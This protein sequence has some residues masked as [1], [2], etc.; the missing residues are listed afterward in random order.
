MEPELIKE[1]SFGG[2]HSRSMRL[3]HWSTV[4]IIL[5]SLTTVLLAKTLFNT[6][7][8][9]PLVK[10]SLQKNNVVITDIQARSVTHEFND[11]IWKWHIYFGYVLAGL[12]LFRIIFEFFQPKDQKIIPLFKNSLRALRLPNNDSREIKHYFIVKCTYILFYFSLFVQTCTGLFM[13]YSDDI[14]SL[15]NIRNTVSDIHSVFMWVIITFIVVHIG[16]VIL[17]EL[18]KNKGI[19]SSMINGSK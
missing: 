15:Q 1:P 19:V 8:T 13:V 17:A 14:D 4:I 10:E 7:T 6:K 9:I 5:G 3:W 18:G 12:L 16:G 11:L 2:K